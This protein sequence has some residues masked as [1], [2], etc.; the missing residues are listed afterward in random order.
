M[1]GTVV[2]A[3]GNEYRQDDG[4]APAALRLLHDTCAPADRFAHTDGEASRLLRLWQGR[5][6]A[7][8]VDAVHAH[9]GCPGR[10]HRLDLAGTA[11]LRGGANTHGLGLGE[12]VELGRILDLLP[13]RLV[14]LG[15]EGEHFGWGDGLSPAVA[16]AVPKAASLV[17]DLLV[18]AASGQLRRPV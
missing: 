6:L 18:E 10:I 16:E 2:I 17:H 13:D 11:L 15:I 14:V 12:A 4:A 5:N 9:P 3:I 1:G 8:V 7:V